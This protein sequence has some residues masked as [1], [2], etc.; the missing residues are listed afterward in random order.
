MQLICVEPPNADPDHQSVSTA[1]NLIT[2]LLIVGTGPRITGKSLDGH[3][4]L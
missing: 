4:M 2:V 3:Q 1:A